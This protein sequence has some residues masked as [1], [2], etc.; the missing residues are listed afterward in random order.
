MPSNNFAS[1]KGCHGNFNWDSLK[2]SNNPDLLF[3]SHWKR[4]YIIKSLTCD[5]KKQKWRWYK[6]DNLI[7]KKTFI[8]SLIKQK[9]DPLGYFK[10]NCWI[11]FSHLMKI[12]NKKKNLERHFHLR[13]K[14]A[15]FLIRLLVHLNIWPSNTHT[16][17]N[18]MLRLFFCVCQRWMKIVPGNNAMCMEE[19]NRSG[20]TK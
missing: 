9:V 6:D 1:L 5:L 7:N 4:N 3:C 13:S 2:C 12:K 20:F 14:T 15:I 11:N 10:Q 8:S 16:G 17:L 18:Y 19:A